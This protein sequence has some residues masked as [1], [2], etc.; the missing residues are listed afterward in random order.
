MV[1]LVYHYAHYLLVADH[2]HGPLVAAGVLAA[3]QVALDK[4]LPVEFADLV[5]A[6]GDGTLHE[7]AALDRLLDVP[8][9]ADAGLRVGPPGKGE[10]AEVPGEPGAAAHDDPRVGPL[11]LEPL[12]VPFQQ[13]LDAH[14]P[15]PA[16]KG[17]R[18]ACE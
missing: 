4:K 5:E 15:A 16:G 11:A 10:P 1:L 14:R 9:G 7:A 3:A 2:Q 13:Y 17:R 12:G 6:H 18:P 8:A